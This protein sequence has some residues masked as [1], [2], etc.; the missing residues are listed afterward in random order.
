MCGSWLEGQLAFFTQEQRFAILEHV[1][2]MGT[3]LGQ[4][5]E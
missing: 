1:E 3:Q 4:K 5:C 2:V